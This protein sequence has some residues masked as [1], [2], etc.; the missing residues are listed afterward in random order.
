M[1]GGQ[2]AAGQVKLDESASGE[3]PAA[4]LCLLAPQ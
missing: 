4:L 1:G 2:G 3:W